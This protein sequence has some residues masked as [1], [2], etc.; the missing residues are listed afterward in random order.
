MS[1]TVGGS[2]AATSAHGTGGAPL[3][4]GG[5]GHGAIDDATVARMYEIAARYP[6]PR[7][8]LLP[9]LHLAQSVEGYVT[10]AGIETCARVLDLTTAEV[11][12]VAT[13]YTMYK[14]HPVGEYHV[15][16]CTNTLC[17]VMGGDA[18]LSRLEEHLGIGHDERT[19][20]GRLSLEHV[21]C[22][23]GCDYAPVVMVNWEFMDNQTPESAVSL[24]EALR[25]GE[26]VRST[27]GARICTFREA[28][29]VLA[30]FNDGRTDEGPTAGP[31]SLAG[32]RLARDRD[33]RAPGTASRQHPDDQQP[34]DQH[35]DRQHE[36][37]HGHPLSGATAWVK[38]HLP[39]STHSERDHA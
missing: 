1:A 26:P 9:M 32:L 24:V 31:A 6:Q 33:W 11:A 13:F 38:D 14:R 18:I 27:R 2:T 10:Q 36:G 12:A 39:G 25:A 23:A 3:V 7:S 15:G 35:P 19:A 37:G 28:E 16:V 30:G 29:A 22:N 20:D 4:T 17:A 8:A 34:D 5:R 21:E